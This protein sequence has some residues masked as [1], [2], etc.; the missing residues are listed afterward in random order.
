MCVQCVCDTLQV[1]M[2][3][4]ALSVSRYC[5]PISRLRKYS[6]RS[7][8]DHYNLEIVF[9]FNFQNKSNSVQ[10]RPESEWY[11]RGSFPLIVLPVWQLF[12]MYRS[13]QTLQLLIFF[14]LYLSSREQEA[15]YQ[16]IPSH[17]LAQLKHR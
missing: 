7:H 1:D 9:K 13:T 6:L 10:E 16:G 2:L 17:E 14:R 11:S 8:T 5:G 12:S 15:N 3:C 4:C